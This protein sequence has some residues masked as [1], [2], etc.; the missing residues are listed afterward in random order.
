MDDA[1]P[2]SLVSAKGLAQYNRLAVGKV[3]R[4]RSRAKC[5]TYIRQSHQLPI[6]H[7]HNAH[8]NFT[9]MIHNLITETHVQTYRQV[10]H[11]W[12]SHIHNCLKR[13][14]TLRNI[15]TKNHNKNDDENDI[16]VKMQR[17]MRLAFYS[18]LPLLLRYTGRS[19]FHFKLHALFAGYAEDVF[20]VYL[21]K[22]KG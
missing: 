14:L 9:I 11:R 18:F 20:V 12:S 4:E 8:K 1:P 10:G 6:I 17:R 21:N 15:T 22:H 13:K 3:F 2:V 16:G 19:L 5:R 7:T